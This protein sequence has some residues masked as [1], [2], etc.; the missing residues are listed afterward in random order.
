MCVAVQTLLLF[1]A[2]AQ[3]TIEKQLN[4][5]SF[6]VS[7]HG[8]NYSTTPPGDAAPWRGC[9]RGFVRALLSVSRNRDDMVAH[10]LCREITLVIGPL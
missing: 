10:A 5:K 9:A 2:K 7:E 6:P 1:T 3:K 8:S 4:V